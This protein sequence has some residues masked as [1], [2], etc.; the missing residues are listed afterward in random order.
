MPAWV[1]RVSLATSPTG[2]PEERAQRP[3]ILLSV[4]CRYQLR[5]QGLFV[6][7]ERRPG[8][9]NLKSSLLP[10][11]PTDLDFMHP[12]SPHLHRYLCALIRAARC[13]YLVPERQV[14]EHG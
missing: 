13:V 8:D 3:P 2:S 7:Q 12:S 1:D 9:T 6:Q 10:W 5:A 14:G 11:S 4:T